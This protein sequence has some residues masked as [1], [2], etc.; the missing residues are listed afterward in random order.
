MSIKKVYKSAKASAIKRQT[1]YK[2]LNQPQENREIINIH[3]VGPYNVGDKYCAP[4]HYFDEINSE[5]LHILNYKHQNSEIRN[6]FIEKVVNNK[7]IIGGGGLL[8]RNGFAKQMHLFEK[9][10]AKHPEKKIVLWG[11]GHNSKEK[12]LY[13]NLEKYNVSVNKFN[14]AGTRDYSRSG[15]YVP[16]VSC[17]HPIFNENFKVTQEI[18]IAFHRHTAQKKEVV[19]QFKNY[20]KTSN[21]SDL[22]SLIEFIGSSEKLITDS[23]HVMYWSMLLEKKVVVVPNSTKF[24]DFKY[25]PVF[26]TFTSAIEDCKKAENY[27]GVLAECREINLNFAAKVFDYLNS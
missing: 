26:S 22:R 24:Y 23:Y 18:G 4:Y 9:L 1:I 2:I 10:A 20:P 5:P 16:C 6:N 12:T 3:N 27:S 8:N 13:G 15:E 19:S 25:K 17:L 14:I 11:V 7:L 21:N